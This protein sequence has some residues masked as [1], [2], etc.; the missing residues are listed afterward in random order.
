LLSEEAP[1]A[2]AGAGRRI[3]IVDDHADG[4][5]SLEAL[6]RML[7]HEVRQARDGIEAI[8]AARVYEPDVIFMDIGMPRLN[9]LDAARR[10]RELP[11]ATRPSIVALT[12]WGQEA[13]RKRSEQAGIDEHL[14]KPVELA[15]LH[16]V[17]DL[18]R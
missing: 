3:L 7:G 8:E 15:A 18:P 11:L 4:A 13:D 10:I 1:P 12:G 2:R 17:L 16:R 9:G 14:V 5:A 6:L